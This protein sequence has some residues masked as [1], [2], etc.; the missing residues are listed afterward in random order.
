[1]Y[2]LCASSNACINCDEIITTQNKIKL[3]S[4]F[5]FLIILNSNNLRMKSENKISLANFFLYNT[6]YGQK[7]GKVTLSC[8]FLVYIRLTKYYK[9][10]PKG[11]R[12]NI[13]LLSARW[14]HWEKDTQCGLLCRCGQI[15]RVTYESNVNSI[16]YLSLKKYFLLKDF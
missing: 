9:F 8:A 11:S 4:F 10:W 3:T 2:M 1:M 15:Y 16:N 7:E 5:F 14:D 6:E 13:L 12:K